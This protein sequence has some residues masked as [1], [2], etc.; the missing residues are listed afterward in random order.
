MSI[1]PG[2]MGFKISYPQG[3][4]MDVTADIRNKDGNRLLYG[5]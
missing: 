5:L 2:V 3:R 1:S 4:W